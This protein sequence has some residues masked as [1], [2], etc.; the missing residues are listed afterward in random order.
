MTDADHDLILTQ[1][2]NQL[3]TPLPIGTDQPPRQENP[4]MS[5]DVEQS[6]EPTMSDFTPTT[7]Q[8]RA[9]YVHDA[10]APGQVER[11]EE[12]DRWLAE[13]DRET[14]ERAWRDGL[15]AGI[16]HE[17]YAGDF[18]PEPSNPHRKEQ[19]DD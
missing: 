6:K 16:E 14:A 10:S 3:T 19:T 17:R 4:A 2:R 15:H 18:D 5:G 1:I 7:E 11:G 8:V 13:H 9:L 12:F